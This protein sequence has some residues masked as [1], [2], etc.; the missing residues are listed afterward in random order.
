MTTQKTL[1]RITAIIKNLPEDS[2][3]AAELVFNNPGE[4]WTKCIEPGAQL[5]AMVIDLRHDLQ[6]ET[7]KSSGNG[8]RHAAA[9]RILKNAVKFDRKPLFRFA[10]TVDGAQ[11]VCDTF[12]GVRLAD[13]LPLPEIPEKIEKPDY[14]RIFPAT[15]PD[16]EPLDLP[17]AAALKAYIKIC[18]A[19][20]RT[21]HHG[22]IVFDFGNSLPVV[23]AEYLLNILDILPNAHAT[24]KRITQG[25]NSNL[26]YFVDGENLGVLCPIRPA[27]GI[28][29]NRTEVNA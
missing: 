13:P 20:K 24:V 26:I 25:F 21:D 11:Y 12:H 5:A 1:E 4:N 17:N 22:A 29:R 18:K 28:A 23:N 19:E 7:A 14:K 3:K 15:V 6:T 8:A 10:A 9:K 27:D 2:R 16:G